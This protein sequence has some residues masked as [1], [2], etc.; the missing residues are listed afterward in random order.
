ML[1]LNSFDI[2]KNIVSFTFYEN[3]KSLTFYKKPI[4]LETP[5]Q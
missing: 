4:T 3:K 5:V 1:S 2:L